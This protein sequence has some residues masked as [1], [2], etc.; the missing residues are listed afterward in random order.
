MLV[1]DKKRYLQRIR[2]AR[3]ERDAVLDEIAALR[4]SQM[5]AAAKIGDG[6]P[7]GSGGNSDLSGY[8]AK[9]DE[10]IRKLADR[11]AKY[12]AMRMALEADLVAMDN[13]VESAILRRRYILGEPWETIA[14]EVGYEIRHVTRI[15]G[16]ALQHIIL[17][18]V[19]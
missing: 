10:L 8:A 15:H 9:L 2:L 6:M 3:P 16:Y 12:D 17:H 19:L 14:D 11:V 13:P 5:S 18:P 1:G 4:A 7:R